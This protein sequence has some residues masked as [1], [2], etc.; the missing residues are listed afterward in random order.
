MA[1]LLF[2]PIAG[3]IPNTLEGISTLNVITDFMIFSKALFLAFH[4]AHSVLTSQSFFSMLEQY[5]IVE[6]L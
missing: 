5:I 3:W 2:T 6:S 1:L 4:T